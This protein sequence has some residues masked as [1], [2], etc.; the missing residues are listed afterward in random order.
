MR[1][2]TPVERHESGIS[3][4]EFSRVL[5]LGATS[6]ALPKAAPYELAKQDLTD[7]QAESPDLS[8]EAESQYR[9]LISR[10]GVR[11]SDEQKLDARRLIEQ[12]MKSVI[13]LRSFKLE[14]ADE[15]AN[16]F[17]ARLTN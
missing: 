13:T 6:A 9:L 10:Y 4:R 7:P 12:G 16:V 8:A 1:K 3:R 11:L 5:A 2:R 15:P 17:T 14:N